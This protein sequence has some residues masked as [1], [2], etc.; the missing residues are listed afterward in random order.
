MSPAN[1][2]DVGEV[3]LN[4]AHEG[5]PEGKA[6]LLLHGFPDTSRMWRKQVPALTEAGYRTIAPDLRGFGES[7]KPRKASA[8]KMPLIVADLRGLLDALEIDRAHVVGH[9]WG[10]VAAWALAGQ[11]RD[12]IERLVAISVGHPRGFGPPSLD[13]VRRT[14]YAVLFQLPRVPEA[15]LRTRDWA[16]LRRIFGSSPDIEDSIRDLSRPGALTAALNW[17]R[18]SGRPDRMFSDRWFPRVD[19]PTMGIWGSKDSTLGEKQ[20]TDSVKHLDGPWR[21]ERMKAGHWIA[22]KRS[23]ELNRLLLDFLD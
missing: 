8:Y 2:I 13:Q 12:R 17:Y 18:A 6:V 5:D 9:D 7:D 19:A 3:R 22:V 21:Y 15:L 1:L 11:A 14:W 23:E 16:L 4:V 20:M 10:A